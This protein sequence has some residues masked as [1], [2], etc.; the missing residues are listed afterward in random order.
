[1]IAFPALCGQNSNNCNC[2]VTHARDCALPSLFAARL[3]VTAF[4]RT[5]A[6]IQAGAA[7]LF[8]LGAYEGSLYAGTVAMAGTKAHFLH[9]TSSKSR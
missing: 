7:F 3:A 4:E 5:N 2:F 8:A 6:F 1:M 9:P